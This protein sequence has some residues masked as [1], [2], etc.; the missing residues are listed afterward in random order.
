MGVL[1]AQERYDVFGQ[2]G[3]DGE[4]AA[5]ERRVAQTCDA[6]VGGELERDEVTFRARD[7]DLGPIDDRCRSDP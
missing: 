2:V 6:V 3:G 4:L 7:D 1:V 5:I